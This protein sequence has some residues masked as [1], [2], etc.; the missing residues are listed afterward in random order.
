MKF[1]LGG[2]ELWGFEPQ[3]FALPAR[4]SS[5][6]SYSPFRLVVLYWIVKISLFRLTAKN[7]AYSRNYLL[8]F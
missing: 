2:V 3:T 8:C 5:Q 7:F 4:R 1:G 6:L